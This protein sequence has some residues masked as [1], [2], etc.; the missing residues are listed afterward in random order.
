MATLPNMPNGPSNQEQLTLLLEEPL[1]RPGPWRV[2]EWVLKIRGAESPL[3]MLDLLRELNPDGLCGKMSPA[4]ILPEI[5]EDPTLPL[6][7]I[8]WLNAGIISPTER[9]TLSTSESHNAAADVF[10]SDV[11]QGGNLPPRFYLSRKACEGILRRATKRGKT[12]P[13]M[14]EQALKQAASGPQKSLA[15]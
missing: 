7:P 13:P 14:L 1:A 3:R 8:N 12:L 5:P 2:K 10:L 11:L 6:S 9:L 4:S 15:P